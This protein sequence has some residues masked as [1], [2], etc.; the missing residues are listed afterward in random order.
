M[1]EWQGGEIRWGILGKEGYEDIGMKRDR[2][3]KKNER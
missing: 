2:G 3:M 1:E